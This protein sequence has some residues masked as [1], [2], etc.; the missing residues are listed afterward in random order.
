MKNHPSELIKNVK[1]RNIKCVFVV[2][3]SLISLQKQFQLHNKNH[4]FKLCNKVWLTIYPNSQFRIHATGIST[5]S[6]FESVLS[7]FRSK[8]IVVSSV[9]V[10]STFWL[11][12]P[13]VIKSFNTFA[14]FCNKKQKLKSTTIDASNVGLNGDAGFLNAI[15]LRRHSCTGTVIIHRNTSLILG[16]KNVK[17][18]ELLLHDL[19]DLISCYE[20]SLNSS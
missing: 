17:D 14:D 5:S 8:H 6:D 2:H 15:Y 1:L 19:Q 3:N 4:T 11:I 13:L 16:S 12:K 18:V 9:A 7:F 10:N 20:S